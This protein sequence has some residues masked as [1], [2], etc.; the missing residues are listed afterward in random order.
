ML[1][2]QRCLLERWLRPVWE[3]AAFWEIFDGQT[4]AT[5]TKKGDMTE[6]AQTAQKGGPPE[7]REAAEKEAMAGARR[8]RFPPP[9]DFPGGGEKVEKVEEVDEVEASFI[10][11]QGRG[12]LHFQAL[13]QGGGGL[14]YGDV[15]M[16][17]LALWHHP[18][19]LRILREW[20]NR[21]KFLYLVDWAMP[22]RN[23]DYLCHALPQ[24][25]ALCSGIRSY[26]RFRQFM[27]Y[28][29]EGLAERFNDSQGTVALR[30]QW[31]KKYRG[32]T[33]MAVGFA[34]ERTQG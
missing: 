20:A 24:G 27:G 7:K 11:V 12:T 1:L 3:D 8:K 5:S 29:L 2:A 28:G 25:L 32:G 13:S 9:S 30:Q 6:V 16:L 17:A 23:I 26:G 22:E 31:H 34:V 19:P 4:F 21:G 33:I 15:A 18:E 14:V 10:T